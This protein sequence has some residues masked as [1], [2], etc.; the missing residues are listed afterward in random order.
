MA[1]ENLAAVLS[2]CTTILFDFDGPICDVFAGMPANQV[3]AN[4]ANLVEKHHPDLAEKARETDDPMEILRLSSQGGQPLIVAIEEALTKAEVAAVAVAGKPTE[5]AVAALEAT[6]ESGR[7]AAI[8]SNNSAE[9]VREFL[10]RHE[11]LHLV[12]EVVGRAHGKPE[13]MKPSPHALSVAAELMSE[14]PSRCVLVGDSVTDVEA[15]HHAG[16]RAIGYANKPSKLHSLAEAGA[17]EVVS[18]ML[19][20]A[21]ALA[22]RA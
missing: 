10:R 22:P 8:V 6:R 20:V 2:D 12:Q 13:L 3:A 17:D 5:G 14:E 18:D 11:I 16:S 21:Q 7:S 19:T 1:D 15:A 9:C 4:L